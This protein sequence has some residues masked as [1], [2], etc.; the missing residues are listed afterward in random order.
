MST[1]HYAKMS[2]KPKVKPDEI[3][4]FYDKLSGLCRSLPYPGRNPNPADYNTDMMFGTEYACALNQRKIANVDDN[5]RVSY[6]CNSDG[7]CATV[8]RGCNPNEFA[9][10]RTFGECS[11]QCGE[12]DR[13]GH[14]QGWECTGNRESPYF[15]LDARSRLCVK[16]DDAP[17]SRLGV[18]R[19][20]AECVESCNSEILSSLTMS[21]DELSLTGSTPW[22]AGVL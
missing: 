22:G 7:A 21:Q 14:S 9:C 11:R 17:G 18:F 15:I 3:F 12:P 8:P 1:A 13:T 6:I 16:T 20:E 5:E 4:Y 10:H 2:R 19:T